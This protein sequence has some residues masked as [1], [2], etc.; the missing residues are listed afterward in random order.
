[1]VATL[2]SNSAAQTQYFNGG[3]YQTSNWSTPVTH[4]TTADTAGELLLDF[5]WSPND[6][7]K[8]ELAFISQASSSALSLRSFTANGSGGGSWSS[9]VSGTALTRPITALSISAADSQDTYI[10]CAKDKALDITCYTGDSTPTIHIPTN[11]QITQITDSGTERSFHTGMQSLFGTY[12]I[13][14]FSDG[15]A[16]INLKNYDLTADTWDKNSTK[17]TS[18]GTTGKT[19]INTIRLVADYQSEDLMALISVDNNDN[20]KKQV[21]EFYSAAWNGTDH[22][23]YTGPAAKLFQVEGINGA[24]PD[25]F[26]YDFAWDPNFD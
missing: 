7:T 1:M 24:D 20:N 17:L 26:W 3:A 15:S 22:G 9:T 4:S 8:G 10:A 19:T 18:V 5:A 13:A 12:G 16:Q 2:G 14:M 23:F 11:G 25:G 21:I 6:E